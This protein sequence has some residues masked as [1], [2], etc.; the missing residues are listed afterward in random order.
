MAG[1]LDGLVVIDASWGMPT[2]ISTM[3][4]A[5]YGARVVKIERPGGGPDAG[6]NARKAT[7]RG[8]WSV[9]AD[10][11]TDEGRAIVRG[12]LA[13]ADVFV[14]S[15]GAG[16]AETLGLGYDELHDEFPELVYVSVTGYGTTGPHASRPG[17]EALL[18]ARLG[19]MAE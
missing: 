9:E 6:S 1:P 10:V 11:R 15:C 17:Y 19:Q 7:D 14:E 12:L 8:K 3:M 13:G 16:R 18:N 5:D 4:L 2:A